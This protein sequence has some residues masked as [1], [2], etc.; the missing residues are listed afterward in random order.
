MIEVVLAVEC[1]APACC[2]HRP[3]CRVEFSVSGCCIPDVAP[4]CKRSTLSKDPILSISDGGTFLGDIGLFRCYLSGESALI[5][6]MTCVEPILQEAEQSARAPFALVLPILDNLVGS[7]D[8]RIVH[9][10]RDVY[11]ELRLFVSRYMPRWEWT[12]RRG[13]W[14]AVR[15]RIVGRDTIHDV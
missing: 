15:W 7:S 10:F 12:A 3:A 13:H 4:D 1:A 6:T 9:I 8:G 5:V 11:S 2:A 14:S